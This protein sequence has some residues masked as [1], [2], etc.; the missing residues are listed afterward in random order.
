MSR[1]TYLLFFSVCFFALICSC[2][3][4][5]EKE[6]PVESVS[7]SQPIAE[8]LVG[9]SIQLIAMIS[10]KQATDQTV[11]WASSKPS[12]AIV[13]DGGIVTALAE[14]ESTIIANAGGKSASCLVT[15]TSSSGPSDSP[16]T[17]VTLDKTSLTLLVGEEATLKATVKPSDAPNKEVAWISGN[18]AIATVDGNGKVSAKS[19]GETNIT[20]LTK[21]GGKKADCNVI[22]TAEKVKVTGISLNTNSLSLAVGETQ[23]L[24]AIITPSNASNKKVDWLSNDSSVASVDEEGNVTG[25]GLGSATIIATTA[26]GGK[27]ATCSVKV[28]KSG[29]SVAVT[30]IKLNKSSITIGVG[31]SQTLVATIE[32]SNATNKNVNWTSNDTSIATVDETGK[33]TGKG[34]GNATIIAT[35]AEGGKKATCSVKV[36]PSSSSVAVTGVSL[37][38]TSL[39]LSVGESATLMATVTPSN[40]SNKEVTWSSD[41]TSVATVD[42][43]GK[44][45][46]KNTGTARI[47]VTTNDGGK[48]AY[49]TVTVNSSIQGYSLSS[50]QLNPDCIVGTNDRLNT[51]RP[52]DSAYYG[53]EP[54]RSYGAIGLFD[55]EKNNTTNILCHFKHGA[56]CWNNDNMSYAYTFKVINYK[57]DVVDIIDGY[58]KNSA[59]FDADGYAYIKVYGENLRNMGKGVYPSPDIMIRKPSSLVKGRDILIEVTEYISNNNAVQRG[60]YYLVPDAGR[61]AKIEFTG[62]GV[63]LGVFPDSNDYVMVHEFMPIIYKNGKKILEWNKSLKEWS[64]TSDG[65]SMGITSSYRVEVRM[66]KLIFDKTAKDTEKSFLNRLFLFE[67]GDNIMHNPSIYPEK[68]GIACDWSYGPVLMSNKIAGYE[69]DVLYDGRS[70]TTVTGTIKILSYGKKAHPYHH[71]DGS[72]WN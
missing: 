65:Y 57:N 56:E 23:T 47:T 64:I 53:N 8:L 12:V 46:A 22:V 14:G 29:S 13:S 41:Q 10:P 7:I 70:I 19:V 28:T 31:E 9:E 5:Q 26:D 30:G 42:A 33:V 17:S 4:T 24:V 72:W 61:N 1:T 11:I 20:V 18:T 35:T 71:P 68:G 37:D 52:S 43:R 27:K 6:V 51:T 60:Y 25:N 39:N 2:D 21:V 59:D 49:C 36:N 34:V 50:W 69:M 40:A 15:V 67:A 38:R 63:E 62:Q 55:P 44:V 45:T 58:T 48:K 16:V 66:T 3:K 32:P 54:Y